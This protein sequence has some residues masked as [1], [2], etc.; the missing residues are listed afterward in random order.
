M[1]Q[2]RSASNSQTWRNQSLEDRGRRSQYE[3]H[4]FRKRYSQHGRQP[5]EVLP[6]DIFLDFEV[7]YGQLQV[8]ADVLLDSLYSSAFR[9]RSCHSRGPLFGNVSRWFTLGTDGGSLVR[10]QLKSQ[11]EITS[12]T[13]MRPKE[14]LESTFLPEVQTFVDS[15]NLAGARI[16]GTKG[17]R[18]REAGDRVMMQYTVGLPLSE[19]PI[20]M[21]NYEAQKI[22]LMVNEHCADKPTLYKA[23]VALTAMTVSG[24]AN[25]TE[26]QCKHAKRYLHPWLVRTHFGDLATYVASKVGS[27]IL[28]ALPQDVWAVSGLSPSAQAFPAGVTDY[29]HMLEVAEVSGLAHDAPASPRQ[30]C[31]LAK[32]ALRRKQHVV[33]ALENL[34][35]GVYGFNTTYSSKE[36]EDNDKTYLSSIATPQ[37]WLESILKGQDLWTDEESVLSGISK[38]NLI[39]KSMGSWRMLPGARAGYVFLECVDGHQDG[40]VKCLGG[41]SNAT[42][43]SERMQEVAVR[44]TQ[45][46]WSKSL[47]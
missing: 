3:G 38:S 4:P 5:S 18:M 24:V 31:K 43:V 42:T 1:L 40:L 14:V 39:F 12:R 46:P 11:L 21:N 34:G 23:L 36:G 17:L 33:K 20:L 41:T 25:Q 16:P 6:A 44:I 28:G 47:L 22:W 32:H 26:T 27:D 7:Q 15:T 10:Q 35:C 45:L 2:V 19:V 29:L 9:H 13:M 30:L 8:T 37:V